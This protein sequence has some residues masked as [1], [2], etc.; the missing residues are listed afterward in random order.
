MA[1]DGSKF[2]AVNNHDNNFT[3]AKM[4]RRIDKVNDSIDRYLKRLDSTDS[5]DSPTAADSVERLNK[6]IERFQQTLEKLKIIEAQMLESPGK[7]ISLTDPDSRAMKCRG[8]GIVGYN[9]QTAVEAK[10]HLIVAHGVTNSASDRDQLF[11]MSKKAREAMNTDKLVALAD[12]G[13]YKSQDI[14]DCAEANIT[15][16]LRKPLTSSNLAKGLFGKGEFKYISEDNEYR[17]P[18][19]ERLIWRQTTEEKGLKLHRYWSSVCREC[20]IKSQCTTG[21]EWRVTRWDHEEVLEALDAR[22]VNDPEKMGV[23]KS[24]VEHPYGTLKMWMGSM[25]FLMKEFKNVKTEMSLHV[26]ADNMKRVMN[27]IG[28]EAI[29]KAI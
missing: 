27:I 29:L 28:I 18:A 9:V 24:T 7:Q 3:P 10:N 6:K 26:L 15:T 2:K 21:R 8:Y 17:C 1:I 25:H 11:N 13:Y 5:E 23:R 20:A 16:Y 19:G 14:L 12:R 4:K 22:V